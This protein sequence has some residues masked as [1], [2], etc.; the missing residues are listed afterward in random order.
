MVAVPMDS[1]TTLSV[2]YS[3]DGKT[4]V[5]AGFHGA[6]DVWNVLENRKVVVLP[7]DRAI[8]RAVTFAA[9]GKTLAS[10]GNEGIVRLWDLPSGT[11]KQ[12]FPGVSESMRQAARG[13]C[14]YSVAFHPDGRML[15]VASGAG[16]NREVPEPLYEMTIFDRQTGKAGW[17]HR[18]RGEWVFSLAFAPD[19]KAIA[20][21]GMQAVT[22]RDA[23][24]GEPLQTLKPTRGGIFAVAYSPDGRKLIGGGPDNRPVA[25]SRRPG[26]LATIWDVATGQVL[27]TLEFP[28][29]D[30][31]TI[32]VSPDGKTV[33]AGGNGPW[34]QTGNMQRHLGEVRLWDIATGK[35][36]WTYE[37]EGNETSS[38]AFSPD[39]RMLVYCD[40]QSVGMIDVQTGRLVRILKTTTMRP[41]R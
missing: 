11:M 33:A 4:L 24:T 34:R 28:S 3:P 9:D 13:A 23:R 21:S 36:L 30:V 8:V 40:M 27:H 39:G 16:I 41:T 31:R 22:L 15:A 19:G 38:L 5:M 2:A 17:S 32:A 12:A 25:D 20:C 37:G 14:L 18:G 29:G 1:D 7:G 35:L 10:A 6:I 26:G